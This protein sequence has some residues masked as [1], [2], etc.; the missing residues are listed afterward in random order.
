MVDA[1][2]DLFS[3]FIRNVLKTRLFVLCAVMAVLFFLVVYRLFNLQILNGEDYLDNYTLS[4]EK[5]ITI[6]G[7]RGNIY[8]RNGVLLAYNELSYTI[9]LEDNGSYDS[10]KAKNEELNAEISTIID[11]I[12]KNGDSIENSL[13]LYMDPSGELS[14]LVDGT[15]LQGFRRDVYGRSSISDLKF[16]TTLGYDEAK[17]S[18]EQMYEY[19]IDE[20][21]VDEDT[22]GRYRAY[23]IMVIRYALSLNSYQKYISTDIAKDVS[24]ETVAMIEEHLSELQGVGVSE[25]TKR[26]YNYPEY[27]CHIIG[28]TGTISQDEYDTLSEQDDSY[29]L[30]DSVGKAGIEQVM[31]LE[32]QGTKG[33]QTVYVNNVGKVLEVKESVD[34]Q[35]GDDVYLSIDSKLQMAVYDM[36]EQELAG[37]VYS[38]IIDAKENAADELYIPI[39]DV[40]VALV[41][42]SVIDIT[43]FAD[44][45]ADSYQQK[46]YQAYLTG[47][48]TVYSQVRTALNTNVAFGELTDETREYVTYIVSWLQDTG[49]FDTTEVN[50]SVE[51]YSDWKSGNIS[52]RDYLEYA[53]ESGW[54]QVSD[55][56]LD[57]KYSDT[58]ETYSALV[59][60]CMERMGQNTAF[61]RLIYKYLIKNDAISGST[62]CVILCEQGILDADDGS[63]AQLKNGTKDACSFLKEKIK[64]LEITPAQLALDPCTGSCVIMDPNTGELLAC[65]TYPGYDTN[66]LANSMDSAYY[67]SLLIDG[68]LPLYDNSTQQ[69]TAPGSTFKMVTAA[70]GLSE[71]V[72]DTSTLIEDTGIFE[73]LDYNLKCWIYPG[74]HGEENVVDAL[75]DSCNYFFCDVG[76]LLSMVGS[77]YS[78]KQGIDR[79]TK[80]A[81][82]FGLGDST[83]L[84]INEGSTQIADEY[85]VSAAIGQSDNKFTTVQLARYVAAI[86][87]EGTVYNLTLLSKM[88]DSDG[89]LIEDYEPEVYNEITDLAPTTWR[90][91]RRG[92]VEVIASHSQFDDL[93]VSLAGK[94][95]TAQENESRPNHSLFVGYAPADD[96]E[97]ALAIRIAYGYGSGNACD[98]ADSVVKYYFGEATTEELL[99]GQAAE[100]E[101]STNSFTD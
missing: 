82:A 87:N 56:G 80:Y 93:E 92:M 32:L 33:Y 66:R 37:I 3:K 91:I 100:V 72:I 61:D 74:N 46:A 45:P 30:N 31:E 22:Y 12:E 79:I 65:V 83:G 35:A 5:E 55:F 38:E 95:G 69:A 94:T 21:G 14:F 99:S 60:Y 28:Y 70:A 9:T 75:R 10:T 51:V 43:Q 20:F 59:D 27:F 90:A 71:G 77:T 47:R 8:D 67:S 48:E 4:I 52:V 53:I 64:N 16:N 85:P 44:A 68:S 58:G 54:I 78:E 15:T 13:S 1:V 84:E 76:Y 17:A 36:L 41:E 81:T 6:D 34:S 98:F 96:P 62:L 63:V 39:Y 2:K 86:A 42:N 26:V 29:T 18:T 23:Q 24:D 97:I 57:E 11:M 19:L 7:T 40:Y 25:D 88:T 89:N 73:E 49:V 101:T 50:G